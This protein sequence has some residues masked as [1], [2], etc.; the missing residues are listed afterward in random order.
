[1]GE[2]IR[3][4]TGGGG[5]GGGETGHKK[6]C[7]WGEKNPEKKKKNAG[8]GTKGTA[9]FGTN[10]N[11]G[12]SNGETPGGKIVRREGKKKQYHKLS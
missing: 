6:P 7:L 2:V 12:V 1:V 8:W 9:Q 5:V 4:G 10:T 11:G 3:V